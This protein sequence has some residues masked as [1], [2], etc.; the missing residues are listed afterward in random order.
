MV[1]LSA[2]RL[3]HWNNPN[4]NPTIYTEPLVRS[5]Y[6]VVLLGGEEMNKLGGELLGA[7]GAVVAIILYS[8]VTL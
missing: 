4:K 2:R 5:M 1:L 7:I 6:I 3:S 8:H